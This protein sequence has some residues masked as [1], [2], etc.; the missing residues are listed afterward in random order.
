MLF[1]LYLLFL[2][3]IWPVNVTFSLASFLIIDPRY[4]KSLLLFVDISFISFSYFFKYWLYNL[5]ISFWRLIEKFCTKLSWSY[6]VLQRLNYKT[7]VAERSFL[8]LRLSL[9]RIIIADFSYHALVFFFSSFAFA[10]SASLKIFL[11]EVF[12]KPNISH[13]FFYC[14]YILSA[15]VFFF[16]YKKMKLRQGLFN[17]KERGDY[18]SNSSDFSKT[19]SLLTFCLRYYNHLT[20]ESFSVVSS[21]LSRSWLFTI[22]CQF[23]LY[24][25]S[26]SEFFF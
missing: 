24:F 4:F 9:H 26:F 21:L 13:L 19:S 1:S 12:I 6:R 22:S 5:Y 15:A 17:P 20:V 8:I 2:P 18:C 25:L 11:F 14:D 3:S 7:K 16:L 23:V 10:T